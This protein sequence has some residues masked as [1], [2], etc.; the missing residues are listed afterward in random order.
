MGSQHPQLC[1]KKSYMEEGPDTTAVLR[2]LSFMRYV[3]S[4]CYITAYFNPPFWAQVQWNGL[5]WKT[6]K[7]SEWVRAFLYVPMPVLAVGIMLVIPG[8]KQ[9]GLW[10][11]WLWHPSPSH[12]WEC[13]R[14]YTAEKHKVLYK[15]MDIFTVFHYLKMI[16]SHVF[17]I[18]VICIIHTVLYDMLSNHHCIYAHQSTKK[19]SVDIP[20]S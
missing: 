9:M 11:L 8:L 18:T 16:H 2:F 20:V 7:F 19:I 3:L 14:G 5:C 10:Q 12:T 1:A 6:N 4:I 15:V 17:D 13:E